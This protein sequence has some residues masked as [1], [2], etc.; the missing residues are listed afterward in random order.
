MN[1]RLYDFFTED[2]R[3][4]ETFFE[5]AVKDIDNIDT[6][7]YQQFKVGILTHIKMEEKGLFLAAQVANDNQPLPMQA[8]LRL[9][10]GAITSLTVP[11]PDRELVNVIRKL[12][13][14]HDNH[15]EKQGGMYEICEKLTEDQ[16]DEV[17]EK[18]KEMGEVPIHPHNPAPIAVAAARRA[19]ERA[20]YD[21]DEM[22][23]G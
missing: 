19:V 13:E 21:Y 4:V 5:K 20:G 18:V 2:H 17:I 3:R 12:L 16:T 1:K 7:L 23:K 8:Q 14:I 11:P 10:H 6:V 9:E 15:E 22:A